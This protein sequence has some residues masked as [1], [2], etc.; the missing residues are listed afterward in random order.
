MQTAI[1]TENLD[2]AFTGGVVAV[3]GLDLEVPRG[4]IYGLIGRN[5]AGKTTTLRLLMGLLRPD[6]GTARI[7][8]A[9]FWEAPRETRQR[10]AYVS[11]R[12]QLPGW[13]TLT[14]LCRYV[15]HFYEGW[16]QA[17][18]RELAERWEL[19]W[20]RPVAQLSAGQQR[21]AAVLAALAGRP[22]V[23]LLDEPA[24][25]LD[26]IARRSLL[27]SLVESATHGTGCTILFSTHLINDLERV[28]DHVGIMDRGRLTMA[29]RLEDLLQAT[30]RVQVVFD[31]PAPPPEFVIPGA[32]RTQVSGPVMT[33]IVRLANEAQLEPIRAWRGV[34]VNVF[35]LSLE[36]AFIELY[37]PRDEGEAVAEAAV[38]QER[39]EALARSGATESAA[40]RATPSLN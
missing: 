26:P 19:A 5:G 38:E 35:P 4:A 32:V 7:L 40:S 13:M 12:Q 21:Q 17:H 9:D 3:A 39:A 18:A 24:A 6:R 30:Q 16:D 37:R 2:K 25:G 28:A 1:Q 14:E 11:Q 27:T 36:E 33:A 29:G 22:E 20:D 15:G 23:L 31:D 34:R 8:G 10:V